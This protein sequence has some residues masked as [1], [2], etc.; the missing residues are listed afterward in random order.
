MNRN[1]KKRLNELEKRKAA[2]LVSLLIVTIYVD[3]KDQEPNV[4]YLSR[5]EDSLKVRRLP[6]EDYDT[7]IKRAK[8]ELFGEDVKKPGIRHMYAEYEQEETEQ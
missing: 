7:F 4:C 3:M 6:D 8:I 5:D 2:H 1:I